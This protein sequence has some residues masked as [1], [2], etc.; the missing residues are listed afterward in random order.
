MRARTSYPQ[1][2]DRVVDHVA[3]HLEDDLALA[4]LARVAGFSPFHF[5]R[6]FQAYTGETVHD[7]VRRVRVER[8][9]S[10]MRA[11]PSRALTDVALEVGFPALSDLSRAFKARFGLAPSRWDRK[12]AL[13]ASVQ[14]AAHHHARLDDATLAARA[15]ELQLRVRVVQLPRSLYVY[16]RVQAPYANN[17][18]VEAYHGTRRWLDTIGRAPSQI[19]FAGMSQDDPAVVPPERCRYDMGILFPLATTGVFTVIAKARGTPLPVAPPSPADVERGRLSV[20]RFP[21][22]DVAT[23]HIDG[24]LAAVDVAWQWLYRTWLPKQQRL[25]AN[26]PAMELFVRLP[27]EIGWERFDLVAAVPLS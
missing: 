18:L 8:A 21:A 7:H 10:L 26:L 3:E 25:P 15:R 24:D 16:T 14:V 9:A 13:P 17:R 27:E 5:H 11:A 2:L 12:A 1:R 6:L 23:L 4:K 20:R 22:I 19:V